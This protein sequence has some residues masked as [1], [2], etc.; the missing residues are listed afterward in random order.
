VIIYYWNEVR[1]FSPDKLNLPKWYYSNCFTGIWLCRYRAQQKS[2]CY[3][4]Y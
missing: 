2:R 3:P 1:I 4:G